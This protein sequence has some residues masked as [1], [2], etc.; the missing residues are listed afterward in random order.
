M[1][2]AGTANCLLLHWFC[3][4]ALAGQGVSPCGGGT[5]RNAAHL[6]C[7]FAALG[8]FLLVGAGLLVLAPSGRADETTVS[9]D[10]LRTGWDRSE[11][12]LSPAT[13]SSPYF[14]RLFSTRLNGQIY[15]QP[16]VAGGV[17]LVATENDWVYGLDPVTGVIRWQRNVGPAWPA[18]AI[19]CT[20]LVPTIGVTSTPVV[21]PVT[22]TAYFTAKVNDGATADSPHWYLHAIDITT[23]SERGG[24]PHVIAGTPTNSPGNPFNPKTAMQRPGLLLLGGVVYAAFASHCDYGPYNGY[25]VGVDAATGAQ[26]TMWSTEAG[27]ANGKGGVWQSGGGLV[28]DGPGRIILATGNGVSPTAGPGS[29]PPGQLGDSVV[30]LQVN[31]D[32]SLTATDFFSPA[33]NAHL[34]QYDTDLGSGGPMGLPDGFG[35]TAHPH[36]LVEVGKDGRVFLLDRDRLGGMAQGAGGTDAVLQTVG[37]Y[38]GVWGHPAFWGGNGGY[39]YTVTNGGPLRAFKV[40]V[41]TSGGPNLT[42]A[43]TTTDSWGYTSGSPVVTSNGTT[44][45]SALVWAQYSTGSTGAGGQLRAYDAVPVNGALG[46]RFF[47]PIGTAAKFA[48]PATSGGRVY[49]GNRDGVVSAFGLTTHLATGPIVGVGGKCVD[50]R[51]GNSGNGTPVQIYTCNRT[52][53][54]QWTVSAGHTLRALAKCLDVSGAGTTNGTKV[55]LWGCN[56]TGAQTWVPQPNGALYNPH[57]GRCLDDPGASLTNGTQLQIYTCNGTA[58]Q[59]WSLPLN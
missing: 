8:A 46:L 18:S 59:K 54:Q 25:L 44:S 12:A 19:G 40:G 27:Y 17:L 26:T 20:D 30:R 16:I 2:I 55:Q 42:A 24:F 14:G 23:G 43:G 36:L 15:A 33:N 21:D 32:G 22:S 47:Y 9:V 37:P 52:G 35:T 58:A 29:K 41:T 48:V 38:R 5:V 4:S 31:A 39:A 1:P 28:S 3:R 51:G 45:G 56:G 6:R 34:D 50:V 7:Y 10:T 49:V 57:S 11:S 13:A 53:A